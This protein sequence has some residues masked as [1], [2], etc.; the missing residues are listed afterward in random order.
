[1]MIYNDFSFPSDFLIEKYN[2]EYLKSKRAPSASIAKIFYGINLAL[3]NIKTI[4]DFTRENDRIF[5][6]LTSCLKSLELLYPNKKPAEVATES[7]Y[8]KI[9][10]SLS[11]SLTE[12]IKLN[13]NE[14][15]KFYKI[16][17]DKLMLKLSETLT[18]LITRLSQ[19]NVKIFKHM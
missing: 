11:D 4:A 14:K 1:M 17:L 7:N 16:T 15:R 6:N 5:E 2:E 12:C 10:S 9:L 19:K 13:L 3:F 8:I 18:E